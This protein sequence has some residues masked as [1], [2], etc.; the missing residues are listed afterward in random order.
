MRAS[1]CRD[2]VTVETRRA[3]L[4]EKLARDLVTLCAVL[5]VQNFGGTP[6]ALYALRLLQGFFMG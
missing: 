2:V 5:P 6:G 1:G 4:D 3:I